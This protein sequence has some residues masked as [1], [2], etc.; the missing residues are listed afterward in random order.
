MPFALFM[1]NLLNF[2][3][4]RLNGI[5]WSPIKSLQLY[6]RLGKQNLGKHTYFYKFL[7]YVRMDSIVEDWQCTAAQITLGL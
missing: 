4:R 2:I 7:C 6:A 1:C 5:S 3:L